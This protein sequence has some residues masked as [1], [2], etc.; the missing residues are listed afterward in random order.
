MLDNWAGTCTVLHIFS[1]ELLKII[2]SSKYM[3]FIA[4]LTGVPDKSQLPKSS[5]AATTM[6]LIGSRSSNSRA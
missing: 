5:V 2:S 3:C 1:Q 6:Q 4:V